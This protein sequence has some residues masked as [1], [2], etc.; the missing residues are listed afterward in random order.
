MYSA[1]YLILMVLVNVGFAYVP[2]IHGWPPM[3][4]AVGLVFV[5]RDLA[6][7]EIG[8]RVILLMLAGAALS[9]FMASPAI[10]FASCAAYLIGETVDW[11]AYTFVKRPLHDRVLISSAVGTPLDSAVFLLLIGHFSWFGVAAMAVSKMLGAG[12]AY[13][14]LRS[15]AE[16][17]A[18]PRFH[19]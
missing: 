1:L 17:S 3:S 6:Q 4:L 15:Q 10:A 12:V 8:H 5:V 19:P 14:W 16:G 7:R 2:L 11:L 18:A 13:F 9:Y